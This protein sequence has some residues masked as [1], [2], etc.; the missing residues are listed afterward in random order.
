M[1]NLPTGGEFSSRLFTKE[2]SKD[3]LVEFSISSRVTN[4][5]LDLMARGGAL[6][7]FR[8]ARKYSRLFDSQGLDLPVEVDVLN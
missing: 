8:R 3:A 5:F 4:H 6:V 7:L 1:E 2:K